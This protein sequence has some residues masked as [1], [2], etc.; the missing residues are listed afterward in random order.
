LFKSGARSFLSIRVDAYASTTESIADESG[1]QANE[2][3]V[4]SCQSCGAAHMSVLACRDE[5]Q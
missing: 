5:S 4:L 3:L 1:P 2:R